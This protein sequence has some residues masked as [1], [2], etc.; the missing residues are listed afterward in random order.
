MTE[1]SQN[2]FDGKEPTRLKSWQA[3]AQ[4]FE[5]ALAVLRINRAVARFTRSASPPGSEYWRSCGN[6][7]GRIACATKTGRYVVVIV[8]LLAALQICAATSASATTLERMSVAK[9]TQAAQL[10]V[11]AQC[12]ANSTGWDGGEIWTFTSFAVEDAW[13]GAPS[14]AAQQLTVRLLGGSVGNL[15]STVSGV[16]RFRPGEEVILFLQ[17]TARG[18]YSIVSWVQGTFRIRRDARSGAEIVVQDTAVFDT[19]D[20]AT[21]QFDVEGIRNLPVGA[22]RMRVQSALAT[23]SG[24]K[25]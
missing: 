18:D 1:R 23:Q 13:K 3:G 16:P 24:E 20:P 9:M 12:V 7:T 22:L 5:P 10:V 4:P 19:Y 15:S 25:K 11:R 17:S 2:K 6:R 8:V 14:G 21:R